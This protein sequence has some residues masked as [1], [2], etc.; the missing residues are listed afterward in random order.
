MTPSSTD[1]SSLSLLWPDSFF[2]QLLVVIIFS[3]LVL[4]C[5]FFFLHWQRLMAEEDALALA[6]QSIRA[7][8]QET[9]PASDAEKGNRATAYPRLSLEELT[10]K[11]EELR[12]RIGARSHVARMLEAI[13][14]LRIHRM[15][16]NLA[17]LQQVVER[18]EA[19][20]G[21]VQ[22]PM[23]VANFAVMLGI[24]GTFYGLGHM[25]SEIGSALSGG[26]ATGSSPDWP[27]RVAHVQQVLSGMRSAFSTSLVGMACSI[28]TGAIAITLSSKQQRLL[29]KL[30]EFAVNELLPATIPTLEDDSV[31]E[32]VSGQLE[33]AFAHLEEVA[34][35]NR[36]SLQELNAV[37]AVFRAVLDDVRSITHAEAA[38]DVGPALEAVVGCNRTLLALVEQVPRLVDAV[39]RL[40]QSAP[41]P[42]FASAQASGGL[43][44]LPRP[45][46]PSRP[47]V[48]GFSFGAASRAPENLGLRSLFAGQS[49]IADPSPVHPIVMRYGKVG[50]AVL[51]FA[52]VTV[53]VTTALVI[54]F[55]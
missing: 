42:V 55:R 3:L 13:R 46:S 52:V 12:K 21:G 15:K 1:E 44:P 8:R 23:H 14:T 35:E 20:R 53:F 33:R 28:I 38:R 18:D 31:L 41:R 54:W 39:D 34:S 17:S 29:Q 19:T 48:P 25:V 6:R 37:Q 30:E 24:L 26:G 47:P 43:P 7:W 45:P 2:T 27:E 11:L 9:M 16:V 4:S 51:A 22:F 36:Q 50:P 5:A 49:S 32:Q 40:H 10:A